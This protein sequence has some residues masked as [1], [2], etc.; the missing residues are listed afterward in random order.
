MKAKSV[1]ARY[2]E[3]ALNPELVSDSRLAQRDRAFREAFPDLE[4]RPVVVAAAGGLVAAHF[5]ARG[6]HVGLFQGVPATGRSWAAGCTALYRVDAGRIAEA[7]ATWDQLA[8]LEQLG[9]IERAA[10][11]SA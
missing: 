2:A 8:L 11:V 10:G 4:L 9:A 6:T 3:E 7:W 1:V 5:A